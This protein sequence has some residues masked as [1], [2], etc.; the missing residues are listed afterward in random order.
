MSP[1]QGRMRKTS[2]AAFLR[3]RRRRY[4]FHTWWMSYLN[5]RLATTKV[6]PRCPDSSD[7]EGRTGPVRPI[8]TVGT[9]DSFAKRLHS[10]L[11]DG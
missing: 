8:W 11:T 7:Q 5:Y 1:G 10:E 2:D 4:S 3:G 9:A 6:N